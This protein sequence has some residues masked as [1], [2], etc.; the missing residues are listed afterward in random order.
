[1]APYSLSYMKNHTAHQEHV[2]CAYVFNNMGNGWLPTDLR[3]KCT[4]LVMPQLCV[5]T[6]KPC[7]HTKSIYVALSFLNMGR[8]PKESLGSVCNSNANAF[9]EK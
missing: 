5:L 1:M 6:E 2:S 4:D 3:E 9:V 8:L 7:V